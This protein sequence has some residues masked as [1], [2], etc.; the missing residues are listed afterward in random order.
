MKEENSKNQGKGGKNLSSL[1]AK[2]LSFTIKED[3]SGNN[4]ATSSQY[5]SEPMLDKLD[6]RTSPERERYH[7][8]KP[9]GAGSPKTGRSP[10]ASPG[11]QTPNPAASA[12]PKTAASARPS[13][14]FT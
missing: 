13:A 3:T 9:R 11:G 4:H 7:Q 14:M 2:Q 12:K 8:Q 6:K 10:V 5:G 1:I